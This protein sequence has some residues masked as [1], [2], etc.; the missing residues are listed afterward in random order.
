MSEDYHPEYAGIIAQ[1]VVYHLKEACEKIEIVGGLRR[2]MPRV[3]GVSIIYMSKLERPPAPPK[4]QTDLFGNSDTAT[5]SKEPR[6]NLVELELPKIDFLEYRLKSNGEPISKIGKANRF[7][8]MRD[9]ATGV[10][11]DLFPVITTLEWGVALT[12][13]TGPAKFN[14]KLERSAK[15]RG[16]KWNGHRITTIRDHKW[17]P[18]LTEEAFFEVCGVKMVKPER[19]K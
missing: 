9:I 19:R 1:A 8:A 10:P 14:A 7:K 15:R 5:S 13:K 16:Y 12:L 2:K 4:V 6:K 3:K 18:A 17:V 11:I